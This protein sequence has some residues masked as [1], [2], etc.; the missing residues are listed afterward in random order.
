ME[1]TEFSSSISNTKGN[2]VFVFTNN[3]E[4]SHFG[5]FCNR[6]K[7]HDNYHPPNDRL[8]NFSL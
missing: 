3:K 6:G 2:F 1:S 8:G 5:T 4:A 7:F